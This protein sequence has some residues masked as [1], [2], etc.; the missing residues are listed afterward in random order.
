ML[1]LSITYFFQLDEVIEAEKQAARDLLREKKKDRA[2]LALKKK[3][4]QEELLKKIDAW[5]INV[6]QQVSNYITNN[7]IE[8]VSF[9]KNILFRVDI[10]F[11]IFFNA[12][13]FSSFQMIK[14]PLSHSYL[15]RTPMSP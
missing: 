6:E 8:M 5:V 11:L 15:R 3:K 13:V 12:C 1:I 14:W 10:F 2:L 7:L 9:R 4:V